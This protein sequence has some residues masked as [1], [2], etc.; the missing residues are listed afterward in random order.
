M[1]RL[2]TYALLCVVIAVSVDGK[3]IDLDTEENGL[4]MVSYDQVAAVL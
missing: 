1:N 4:E 3:T 2:F